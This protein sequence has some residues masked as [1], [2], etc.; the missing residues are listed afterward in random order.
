MSKLF[1]DKKYGK[2]KFCPITQSRLRSGKNSDGVPYTITTKCN[3]TFY[4]KALISWLENPISQY[5]CPLCRTKL[6]LR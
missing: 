3:H 4:R 6:L 2:D 1:W 5:L